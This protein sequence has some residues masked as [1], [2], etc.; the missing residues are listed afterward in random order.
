MP[1]VSPIGRSHVFVDR[2]TTRHKHGAEIAAPLG[3][4]KRVAAQGAHPFMFQPLAH[5]AS[6]Q[7][8]GGKDDSNSV[9]SETFGVSNPEDDAIYEQLI[10][11]SAINVNEKKLKRK[12]GNIPVR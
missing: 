10:E 5:F 1:P 3:L 11:S 9:I 6:G 2:V 12:R 8:G 4:H 7:F